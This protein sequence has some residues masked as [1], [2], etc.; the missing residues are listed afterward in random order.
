METLINASLIRA[1]NF[2][3][4]AAQIEFMDKY[5]LNEITKSLNTV[6]TPIIHKNKQGTKTLDERINELCM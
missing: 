6:Y 1:F 2:G 5:S 3:H 4:E